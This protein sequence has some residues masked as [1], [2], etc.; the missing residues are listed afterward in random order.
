MRK[1]VMEVNPGD[2]LESDIFNDNGVFVLRKGTPLTSESI[3]KLVQHNIDYVDIEHVEDITEEPHQTSSLQK[4]EPQFN[5]AIH[6]FESIFLEALTTGKFDERDVDDL[7]QPIM[8][9][10]TDQKDVV[11]LLL[12]LDRKD[13]YTY[14]HSMQVGMLSYYI[15]L[16]LGYSQPNAYKAGKAGFLH[17]IGKSKIPDEILNKPGKLTPEEY[18]IIKLHTLHGYEI[19]RNSVQDELTAQVA[20]QH[21]EREDGTG[22]PNGLRDE[23]IHPFA[24]ITAIADVYSAMT[25]NRVYQNKK[26]LISVLHELYRLSFGKFNPEAT[27][28][29][30]RHMI[31]N[32]IG[33]KVRLSSGELGSIVMTNPADFFRPL[34]KT[35]T[36]FADLSRE[37]HIDIQEIFI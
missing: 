33:K 9:E 1:H 30:I 16:W 20:L 24:K 29:F 14:N 37:S 3:V 6:A 17:D 22:Y 7:L 13:N 36:R 26:E 19:I 15:A 12:M 2:L 11:S 27:Q 35:E 34:V 23:Q 10:L 8:H 31:P 5:E 18:E 28:A 25:S 4:L 32:F 21:H